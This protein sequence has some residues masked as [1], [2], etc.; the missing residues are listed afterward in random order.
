MGRLPGM[1]HTTS[2][3]VLASYPLEVICVDFTRLEPASDGREDELIITDVFTKFSQAV[4][5]R[6]QE[7]VTVAKVLVKEWFQ[8]YGVPRR[9]HSDQGMSFEAHIIK[10]LW[11]VQHTEI[12]YHTV[13]PPREWTV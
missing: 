13:P 2:T 1:L 5:T 10:E 7:A 11:G 8:K 12:T 6:N 3:P 4:P 9:I